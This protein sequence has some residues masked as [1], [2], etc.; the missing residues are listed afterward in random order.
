MTVR[1]RFLTF[2]CLGMFLAAM[3][4]TACA[5][6]ITLTSGEVIDGQ[7]VSE[8]DSQMDIKTAN[9]SRTIFMTRTVAKSDIKTVHR[10]SPMKHAEMTAY[11][12][13][14]KY[15]LEVNQEL[16]PDFYAQGLAAFDT[17]LA[18]YTNSERAAEIH[19]RRDQWKAEMDQVSLGFVKFNNKWMMPEEKKSLAAE[20]HMQQLEKKLAGLVTMVNAAKARLK[21]AHDAYS[22]LHDFY[23]GKV[24]PADEYNNVMAQFKSDQ[25]EIQAAE[26]QLNET[27]KTY[28]ATKDEYKGLG[29][30]I[31]FDDQLAKD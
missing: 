3:A 31:N 15:Q 28:D 1:T 18:T 12:D 11:D 21:A 17:F 30:K 19:A 24:L 20:F 22:T 13:L 6:S 4:T 9:K 26:M 5:D 16:R 10:E 29:G 25:D 27:R 8:T 7:I 23:H 2:G 14:G